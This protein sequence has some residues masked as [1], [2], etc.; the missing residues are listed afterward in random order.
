MRIRMKDKYLE[1]AAQ[2]VLSEVLGFDEAKMYY[3]LLNKKD[4]EIEKEFSYSK[5]YRLMKSLFELGAMAKIKQEDKDFFSYILLPPTFLYKEKADKEIIE[6]LEK[7]YLENYSE[8]FNQ[9]FSQLI[10]KD[11]KVLLI[12]L[13]KY[14]MKDEAKLVIDEL[15][16]E[17]LGKMS[18]KIT[19]KRE[20]NGRR[21]GI[22]DRNLAF[23]FVS[24]R[25]EK[26]FE[27]IGYIARRDY[28]EKVEK[29]IDII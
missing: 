29:E 28:I 24:M 3:L 22:I 9:N 11:E 6:Y 21:T 25:N 7:I 19:I 13:L 12:F 17:Y 2:Q 20:D 26:N 23:E 4:E 8:I 18:S 14:F 10:L 5:K 27:Y 15:D 1:K 16:K